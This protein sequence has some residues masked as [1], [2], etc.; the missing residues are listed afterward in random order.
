MLGIQL[1]L[2]MMICEL[3]RENSNYWLRDRP[4][5]ALAKVM[6]SQEK[7]SS[8]VVIIPQEM[9]MGCIIKEENH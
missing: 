1:Y 3:W 5:L 8:Q 2:F 7:E 9:D 6:V 4:D